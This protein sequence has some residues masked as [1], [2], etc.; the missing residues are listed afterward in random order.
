MDM[1]SASSEMPKTSL[2]E[3]WR[4]EIRQS[5]LSSHNCVNLDINSRKIYEYVS[6]IICNK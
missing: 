2:N 5:I 3:F 4:T 1:Y 6:G